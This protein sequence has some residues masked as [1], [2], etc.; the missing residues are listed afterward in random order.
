MSMHVIIPHCIY[1]TGMGAEQPFAP[2]AAAASCL[3][4]HD[5]M[6]VGRRR[7][8]PMYSVKREQ[9]ACD[10]SARLHVEC[11]LQ[12]R[13]GVAV[14]ALTGLALAMDKA[15][16]QFTYVYTAAQLAKDLQKIPNLV[17]DK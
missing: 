11:V 3:P 2:R 8:C 14:A 6:E 1:V 9:Q 12:C 13:S 15:A 4:F 5:A 7:L 17:P 10:H 16:K